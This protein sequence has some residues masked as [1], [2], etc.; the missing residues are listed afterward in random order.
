[1]PKVDGRGQA[2]ILSPGELE[3][4][5]KL[6]PVGQHQTIT[7]CL[8]FTS[9]RVSEVL[10][11]KWKDITDSHIVFGNNITK[12]GLTRE[13]NLHPTLKEH[14]ERYKTK[15]WY[16]YPLLNKREKD[17]EWRLP[18]SSEWLFKGR[19]GHLTR[20]AYDKQ[21]RAYLKA[22]NIKGGS[23]HTFRRSGLSQAKNSGLSLSDIQD[24]SGHVSLE[25]LK[26]YLAP[27]EKAKTKVVGSFGW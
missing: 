12:T 25:A 27:N 21:L 22:I 10:Q 16:K 11:L 3:T 4:L 7:Y 13:V 2:T 18:D 8:T 20:Q 9:A 17:A 26:K 19:K 14:L 23:C 5:C 15:S 24:I 6:I 1:M